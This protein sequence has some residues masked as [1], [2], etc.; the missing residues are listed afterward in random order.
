MGCGCLVGES[1]MN[2]RQFGARTGTFRGR[3][4]PRLYYQNERKS[5][6]YIPLR[7]FPLW[8]LALCF[9]L[10]VSATRHLP[11]AH[12]RPHHKKKLQKPIP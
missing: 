11:R 6:G 3:V 7:P 8:I 4:F 1:E 9:L 10:Q 5:W 12:T 2:Y